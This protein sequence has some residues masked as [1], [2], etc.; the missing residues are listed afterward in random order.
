MRGGIYTG[1]ERREVVVASIVGRWMAIPVRG[2]FQVPE[3]CQVGR[4]PVKYS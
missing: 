3:Y 1:E 2:R 4:S